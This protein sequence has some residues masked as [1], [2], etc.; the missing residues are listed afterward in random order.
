VKNEIISD[1]A[2]QIGDSMKAEAK[3]TVLATMAPMAAT[4]IPKLQGLLRDLTEDPQ[5]VYSRTLA[6]VVTSFGDGSLRDGSTCSFEFR[7]FLSRVLSSKLFDYIDACLQSSFE[8]SGA[9]LQDLINE[10]G[11]RL[12]YT[13]ENGLYQG[14]QNAIGHDGIWR[15]PQGRALVIEVKT[16]DA[17]RINLDVIANYRRRLLEEGRIPEE[18]SILIV[19]GR[20]DTGDLE[21][22]VRGSRHA[23]T[24]RLISMDALRKLVVLKEEGEEDTVGKIHELL[25]PFEYT[26]LDRMIDVA[27]AVAKEATAAQEES[28]QGARPDGDQSRDTGQQSPKQTHTPFSVI[29]AFRE[30][31]VAA[32]VRR[33]R[34][35]LVKKSAA[36]YWSADQNVRA[37]CSVSTRY[38]DGTYWYAYHPTWNDFLARGTSATYALGCGDEEVLFALPHMWIQ[39]RLH[40]LNTTTT[41]EGKMYWHVKIGDI[42]SAEPTLRLPKAG[43]RVPIA[44]FKMNLLGR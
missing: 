10:L 11:R 37:I 2:L 25:W 30:R 36:Q 12:D 3:P 8:R 14:K 23:W 27:F 5:Y 39:E 38:V 20:Q 32:L 42:N 28:L 22:Q 35:E 31:M 4:N 41:P 9:I 24:T 13:I 44:E 15:L 18:S 40:L 1:R 17:Y 7:N 19:V 43:E 6:Q 21:A 16:T 26:R 34:T 33:D 29:A